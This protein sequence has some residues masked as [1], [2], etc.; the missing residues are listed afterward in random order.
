MADE[1]HHRDRDETTA[2]RAA[3]QPPQEGAPRVARLGLLRPLASRTSRANGHRLASGRSRGRT[4]SACGAGQTAAG[5]AGQ[6]TLA[7]GGH[8]NEGQGGQLSEQPG[9]SGAAGHR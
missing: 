4:A 2:K 8:E 9:H 3:E 5:H 7:G 6:L 1:L